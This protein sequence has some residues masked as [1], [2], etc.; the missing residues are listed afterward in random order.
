MSVNYNIEEKDT[1]AGRLANSTLSSNPAL[2]RSASMA[3]R[4]ASA[5]GLGRSTIAAGAGVGAYLDQAVDIAKTDSTNIIQTG[6]QNAINNTNIRNTD[7]NNSS[8]ETV[9]R[10][11]TD[12]QKA[13]QTEQ[14]RADKE[15]LAARIESEEK[16]NSQNI[17]ANADNLN[18]E[19]T[20]RERISNSQITADNANQ[21]ANRDVERT[22]ISSQENIAYNAIVSDERKAAFQRDHE[23]L[24]TSLDN[25]N[26]LRIEQMRMEYQANSDRNDEMGAAWSNYQASLASIDPNATSA[27]QNTMFK[28]ITDAFDARMNFISGSSYTLPDVQNVPE[29]QTPAPTGTGYTPPVPTPGSSGYMPPANQPQ[30]N[31]MSLVD[32]FIKSSKQGLSANA[33]PAET[34]AALKAALD[35]SKQMGLSAAEFQTTFLRNFSMKESDV[36]AYLD[37]HY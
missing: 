24:I 27:S 23:R 35:Y 21:A 12:T 8:Q 15:S 22:R 1:V 28:R 26:R 14:I 6:N 5:K 17:T 20:V 11:S 13:L 32:E 4:I 34:K 37:K 7:A 29:T 25:D 3:T 30:Q 31:R 33:S 10:L 19:L 9:A 36:K 16:I 18:K 2:R